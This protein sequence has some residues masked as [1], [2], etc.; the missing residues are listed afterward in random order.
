MILLNI[1]SLILLS[2][3]ISEGCMIK[4]LPEGIQR[5]LETIKTDVLPDIQYLDHAQDRTMELRELSQVE[6]N[7]EASWL[8]AIKKNIALQSLY[9]NVI[10]ELLNSVTRSA[11]WMLFGLVLYGDI[12]AFNQVKRRRREVKPAQGPRIADRVADIVLRNLEKYNRT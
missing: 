5:S 2:A 4:L 1:F 10:K 9:S 7:A 11:G 3:R 12:G 6:L 8:A